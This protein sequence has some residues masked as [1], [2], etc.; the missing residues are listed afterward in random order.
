MIYD[1]KFGAESDKLRTLCV[2][3][4]EYYK[5]YEGYTDIQV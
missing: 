1:I 3:T 5:I 2:K 4:L